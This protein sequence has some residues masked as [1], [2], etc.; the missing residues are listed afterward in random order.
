MYLLM[1]CRDEPLLSPS[2][3]IA[4]TII[5][6]YLGCV[7]VLADMVIFLF[8]IIST[9]PVSGRTEGLKSDNIGDDVSFQD[10]ER[11]SEETNTK[12]ELYL[13]VTSVLCL[14]HILFFFKIDSLPLDIPKF[15][16][17]SK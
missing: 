5:S 15:V 8:T 11:T 1:A 16:Y 10:I 9:K 14:F 4:L 6:M 3:F 12:L 7:A 13:R 2:A 17:V